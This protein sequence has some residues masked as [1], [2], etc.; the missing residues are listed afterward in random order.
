MRPSFRFLKILSVEGRF[1]K[2]KHE[3]KRNDLKFNVH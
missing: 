2:G 3:E 1:D